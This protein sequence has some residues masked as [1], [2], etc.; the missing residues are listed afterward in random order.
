MQQVTSDMNKSKRPFFS[1][2]CDFSLESLTLF[3]AGGKL[4]WRVQSWLSPPD[5]W[6]NHNIACKSRHRGSAAWFVQGNMFSEWKASE[7][8]GSLLWVHGKRQ[9]TFLTLLQRLKSSFRSRGGEECSLVCQA[10][11]L[12]VLR[13]YRVGQFHNHRGHW[14]DAKSG[15]RISSLLLL[16]F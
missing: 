2:C 4:E 16:R 6:K 3:M 5:P 14:C 7:A 12:I 9:S 15:A 10:F 1:G 13:I 8:R 11:D